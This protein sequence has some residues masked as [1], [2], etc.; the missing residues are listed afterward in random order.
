[1]IKL[2]PLKQI[3]VYLQGRT[4][5]S[6]KYTRKTGVRNTFVTNLV[7]LGRHQI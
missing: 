1:M 3:W 7:M 4:D 6:H 2:F 5:T